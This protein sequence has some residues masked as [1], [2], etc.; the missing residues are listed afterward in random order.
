[1]NCGKLKSSSSIG[2]TCLGG[3]E[4]LKSWNLWSLDSALFCFSDVY[5]A[6]PAK[7]LKAKLMFSLCSVGWGH[8]SG[9][10]RAAWPK[11]WLGWTHTINSSWAWTM[12][13]AKDEETI[14]LKANCSILHQNPL[15]VLLQKGESHNGDI[16]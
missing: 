2:S 12:C 1:M 14:S 4:H 13:F 10:N 9:A 7:N 6:F 3:G 16:F 11:S 15:P 8:Q 5:F